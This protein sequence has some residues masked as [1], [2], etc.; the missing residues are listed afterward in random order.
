SGEHYKVFTPGHVGFD[1]A[2]ELA[3]G[4]APEPIHYDLVLE[5]QDM[6][7]PAAILGKRHLGDDFWLAHSE[8]RGVSTRKKVA[9][10]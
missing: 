6:S 7:Y 3:S 8:H 2:L 9:L 5:I 4:F 10:S 1:R